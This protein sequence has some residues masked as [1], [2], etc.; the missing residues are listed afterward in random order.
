MSWPRAAAGK[1]EKGR[2]NPLPAK[3]YP[4]FKEFRR[5]WEV[6]KIFLAFDHCIAIQN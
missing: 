3:R 5:L 1:A 2:G 4:F 6:V